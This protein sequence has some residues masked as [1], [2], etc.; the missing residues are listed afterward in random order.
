MQLTHK[1]A[2]KSCTEK[3]PTCV[4]RNELSR[5]IRARNC[6]NVARKCITTLFLAQELGML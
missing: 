1:P 4:L 3:P 5:L 6:V 2:R